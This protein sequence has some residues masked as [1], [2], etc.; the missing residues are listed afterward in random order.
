VHGTTHE[1]PAERFARAEAAASWWRSTRGRP[2][3]RERVETRIVPRDGWWRST[4][5]AIRCR[6]RGRAQV[7]VQLRA[8]EVVIA[9]GEGE[10]VRH[11]RLGQAPGGALDGPP[12]AC[13]TP[14]RRSPEL[15]P[16]RFDPA[17]LGPGEVERASLG[18]TTRAAGRGGGPM[19]GACRWTGCR[20][21]CGAQARAHGRG[22][23]AAARGGQ[24]SASSPTATSS[25][26]WC[27]RE[28]AA[29]QERHTR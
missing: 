27:R 15:G 8:E 21:R 3:P 20:S 12:R 23:A 4:P 28:L 11:E 22:A 18:A 7:E 9:R 14:D 19:S 25:R 13:P 10:P 26:S 29:K 2:T 16:P 24:P 1:R 17:L 6:C 5:I